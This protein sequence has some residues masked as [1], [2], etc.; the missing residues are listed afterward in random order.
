M[1]FLYK[2]VG[3]LIEYVTGRIDYYE[4]ARSRIFAAAATLLGF[5]VTMLTF[6]IDYLADAPWLRWSVIILILAALMISSND[7]AS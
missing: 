4:N 3:K 2:R 5:G 7:I 6:G 1:D